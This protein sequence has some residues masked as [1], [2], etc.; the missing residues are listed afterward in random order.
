[1]E[2]SAITSPRPAKWLIIS[3]IIPYSQ[4]V[5]PGLSSAFLKKRPEAGLGIRAGMLG[6]D[7]RE[8]IQG[9]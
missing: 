5:K 9:F 7:F 4:E 6:T 8:D 1:M 2:P 3:P